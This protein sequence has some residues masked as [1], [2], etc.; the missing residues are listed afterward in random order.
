VTGSSLRER[1]QARHAELLADTST[2]LDVP[3]YEGI[4]RGRYRALSIKEINRIAANVAKIKGLDADT[5]ELYLYADHLALACEA[6][7]DADLDNDHKE[8]DPPPAGKKWGPSLASDLGFEATTPRQA[9]FATIPRDT[10]LW[11]H[12]QTLLAWQDGE[13]ERIA[14]ETVGE[15]EPLT[16]SS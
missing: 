1:V 2:T 7:Y 11:S 15:S 9:V 4:L 3:G 6:V 5:R 14:D 8:G 13:N 16:S 10:M 12:Y